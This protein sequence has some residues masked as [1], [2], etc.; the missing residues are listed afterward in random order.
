MDGIPL[1]GAFRALP[2]EESNSARIFRARCVVK[3]MNL[4]GGPPAAVA[5]GRIVRVAAPSRSVLRT[6]SKNAFY[7]LMALPG[8][9]Y[10]LVF[11]Y[12]P[13][14]GIIIAF[15]DV[16]PFSSVNDILTGPWVGFAHFKEFFHSYFFWNV[17]DN[18]LIISGLKLLVGF[19]A[20]IALA[21]LINEVRPV[22]FKRG[23]QT[24][25]YLPH[26]LSMVIV[27]GLVISLLSPEGGL[28][29][30]AVVLVGGRPQP[31]L[32]DPKYFRA[33]LVG[34]SLWQ[35]IG[36]GSILYLAAM[37]N[38]DPQLYEAAMIDGA[39]KWQQIWAVT[40]PGIRLVIV[41]VLIFAIGGILNA[42]FEQ[43]LLLYSPSVYSVGDIID[44][45]VY[46]RGLLEMQYSF[47][48]AVGLFKAVLAM[49]LLLGANWIAHRLGEE[50]IW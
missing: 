13:M 18:T 39:N 10:F 22:F 20:P 32:G 16:T 37:V 15:K 35:D 9:L 21:L 38:I 27:A 5:G 12:I 6:L 24:I 8:L 49:F 23:V 42:G 25:S 41:I 4:L 47:A 28:V 29:N 36:W 34:T 26:F 30:Q 45:F 17:L 46:R 7:Y 50:G 43:V 3:T 19:P 44:T 2:P 1:V 31:F 48:A 14:F 40:L 33:I 11:H